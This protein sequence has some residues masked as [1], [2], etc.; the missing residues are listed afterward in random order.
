M[1]I[2]TTRKAF[3]LA[4]NMKRFHKR[5]TF[6]EELNLEFQQVTMAEDKQNIR[7]KKLQLV[8][9]IERCLKEKF[10]I[11]EYR[12]YSL[13]NGIY[14]FGNNKNNTN[15]SFIV[16][17]DKNKAIPISKSDNNKELNTCKE[18]LMQLTQ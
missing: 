3:D 8:K 17:K 9:I 18:A 16:P 13:E 2:E 10:P 7:D 1:V 11:N 14:S 4:T 6:W 5:R 15:I 12:L